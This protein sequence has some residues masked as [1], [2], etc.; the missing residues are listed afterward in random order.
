MAALDEIPPTPHG[1]QRHLLAVPFET[2]FSFTSI[3]TGPDPDENG[4][5]EN[6]RARRHRLRR[7]HLDEYHR[8]VSDAAY[9]VVEQMSGNP[10]ARHGY[11][12]GNPV[13]ARETFPV[14]RLTGAAYFREF[15]APEEDLAN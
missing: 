7:E 15:Y 12:F 2:D 4:I 6:E 8:R 14:E 9:A 1:H 13:E 5:D 3:V 11:L 10:L